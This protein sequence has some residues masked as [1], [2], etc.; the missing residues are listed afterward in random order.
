MLYDQPHI[1]IE[2]A[3]AS[4]NSTKELIKLLAQEDTMVEAALNLAQTSEE[5]ALKPIFD[6]FKRTKHPALSFALT[7]FNCTPIVKDILDISTTVTQESQEHF[8]T[9][10]NGTTFSN[11]L[12]KQ[13]KNKITALVDKEKNSKVTFISNK[14]FLSSIFL[15]IDAIK[16]LVQ[17]PNNIFYINQ[18]IRP[19]L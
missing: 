10:L 4:K 15:N 1:L 13:I 17:K 3:L 19:N 12:G 11:N 14:S 2:Q 16:Q 18:N 6:A 7:H 9:I 8:L 5:K